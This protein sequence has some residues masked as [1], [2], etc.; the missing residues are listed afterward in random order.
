M[1]K[2]EL[3]ICRHYLRMLE[4]EVQELNLQLR[5][6]KENIFELVQAHTEAAAQ[7]D[8]AM[9]NPRKISEQLVAVRKQLYNFDITARGNKR[10]SERLRA[11]LDGLTE[12][13]KTINL[14]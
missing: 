7:R 5:N 14:S 1:R 12:R 11:M 2:T 10:E 3:E 6:A 13:P 8:E 9:K 4:N